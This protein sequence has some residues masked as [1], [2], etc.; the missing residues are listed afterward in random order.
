MLI[1]AP[2]C[3]S[4]AENLEVTLQRNQRCGSVLRD[5]VRILVFR[6]I[7]PDRVKSTDYKHNPFIEGV[8]PTRTFLQLE[9]VQVVGDIF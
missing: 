7:A 1:I 5:D 9:V 8:D 6:C 4:N 3:E 2:L